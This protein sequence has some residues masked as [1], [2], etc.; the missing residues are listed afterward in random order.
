MPRRSPHPSPEADQLDRDLGAAIRRFRT[1]LG[2]SQHALAA[3]LS[4]SG[5][6]LQKYES[7]AYRV[8]ASVLY[9]LARELDQPVTAF[10]PASGR[11]DGLDMLLDTPEGRAVSRGFAR[12]HDLAQRRALGVIVEGLARSA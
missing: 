9:R 2:L 7:G 11:P 10:F 5:Q 6:Q 3:R 8:S 1:D 12:I 4:L